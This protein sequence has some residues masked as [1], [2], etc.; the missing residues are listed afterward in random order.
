MANYISLSEGLQERIRQDRETGW[1]NPYACSNEQVV[2]RD[3][4]HDRANLWRPAFV[5]DTEKI[6][7]VPFYSRYMD[8]TQVFSLVKNDDVC[9]RALH[10]QLVSRIARNIGSML[11]LNT[12]LIEAI[13]L[14]HDIGHTPFGHAGEKKLSELYHAETGRYFNH[15]IHSARVLDEIFALNLS[16]QTLDGIICHNGEMEARRYE[17]EAYNDFAKFDAKMESCYLDSKANATLIPNTLEGCVMRISDIIAYL[18][19]DRQDAI[20]LGFL[21]KESEFASSVIGS[22]NAEIINNMIVNI[23]ENSY[24]RDCLAMDDEYF[25]ALSA[26]KK[27]NYEKIYHS[28]E[29]LKV[30]GEKLSPMFEMMFEELLKE[31]RQRS[32]DSLLYR[33][34]IRYIENHTAPYADNGHAAA[35]PLEG[36]SKIRRRVIYRENDPC[37]LVVDFMAGMTDDYFVDLFEYMFPK[38]SYK[39]EYQ[40]YF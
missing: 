36:R 8:K 30:F 14:G 10:V 21:P 17:P 34:H 23:I 7:H 3:D 25:E 9:R 1:K 38:S 11:G 13:S 19:K 6:M 40:G 20:R 26:A 2:R 15:N 22:S 4:S 37:D 29:M 39:V 31:A 18:G 27:E 35:E 16:L 24:G 33:H 32:D 5:R 28:E 12:D